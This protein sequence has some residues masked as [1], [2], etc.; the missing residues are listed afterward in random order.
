MGLVAGL[1]LLAA[2]GDREVILPG[3]RIDVRSDRVPDNLAPEAAEVDRA[4][5][6]PAQTVLSEWTH[7][8]GSRV[9]RVDHPALGTQLTRVWSA[10]IGAGN[11]RR[12]R[13]SAD[14]VV[15]GGIVYTL[16]SSAGV[17]ATS[18]NGERFWARSLVPEGE[19]DRDSTGGGMAV[20]GST[21]YV[22]SGFG[23]LTALD[24]RSG[25]EKWQQDLGAPATSAPTVFDGL[26]YTVSRDNKAWALDAQNGR[27][28][29][30]LQGT[31]SVT[32]FEGG[33][34]PAVTDTY[35]V[36][37]F[38]SGELVTA[39]RQGGVRIWG[40]QISGDRAGRAYANITDIVADPVVVDDVIYTGNQSGR[41]VALG[42]GSGERIWTAN[43]G[44][45]GPVWVS[46]GSVFLISDRNELLRLDA[47]T[48]ARIW[49][50]ELPYYR[51]E[52]AKR[53]EDIFAHYGPVLAGGRLLVAS[54]DGLIRSFS[55]ES[56]QLVGTTEL[57]GGAA[58]SM[59]VVNR[60][61][62]VVSRN[63]Q[64]HAFR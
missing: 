2:C 36:F 9:H 21:L 61:L 10:D 15:A 41:A 49:G 44:A 31:P 18:A 12:A 62:Y 57:P 28:R 13:I 1:A 4:F 48:G 38:S 53:R 17:V 11:S 29:W 25:A 20:D 30:T 35:A 24:A 54:D 50:A 3:E 43:E 56:G 32:G 40:N 16:D 8:N 34:G 63:G 46:G 5:A 58:S 14:P 37:P 59:A 42:L 52:R 64:L 60:T 47:A 7:E 33:S 39:L 55:P 45:Y 26:V 23:T 19:S 6:M 27:I 51:R 22:T